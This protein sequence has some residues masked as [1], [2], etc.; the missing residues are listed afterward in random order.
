MSWFQCPPKSHGVPYI[1][2]EFIECKGEEIA[3]VKH[4][5]EVDIELIAEKRGYKMDFQSLSHNR[6]Y[7]GMAVFQTTD[8]IP[9][10][11]EILNCAKYHHADKGTIIVDKHLLEKSN[12]NRYRFTIGHELGHLE[13]HTEVYNERINMRVDEY[14]GVLCRS[15]WRKP[16]KDERSELDWIE[17]QANIFSAATLM[18]RTAFLE[19]ANS[20][21]KIS[22]QAV[23]FVDD[24][25]NI[26]VVSPHAVCL[27]LSEL[28]IM[29]FPYEIYC[30]IK[31]GVTIV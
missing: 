13:M 12:M 3:N 25:S 14:E 2:R 22:E 7:L 20:Y 8:Y 26:F 29:D 28:N 1:S 27:R 5:C 9:I 23:R 18:P 21:Y 15:A 4:P 24:A 6:C 11:D 31:H 10:Y 30:A 19:L 17:V 16:K